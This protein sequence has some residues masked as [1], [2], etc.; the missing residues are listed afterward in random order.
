MK[1]LDKTK[2]NAEFINQG[3]QAIIDAM[4]TVR[5]VYSSCPAPVK[6]KYHNLFDCILTGLK[7]ARN[8]YIALGS[9]ILSDATLRMLND[10]KEDEK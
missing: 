6:Q 5:S 3:N 7:E 1:F 8:D 10:E 2:N 4:N 9:Y